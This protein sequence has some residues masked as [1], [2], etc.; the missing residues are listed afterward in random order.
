[1]EWASKNLKIA[2]HLVTGESF[3]KWFQNIQKLHKA[4][5]LTYEYSTASQ[6]VTKYSNEQN[7]FVDTDNKIIVE[8]N[9]MV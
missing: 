3:L 6:T 5:I 7:I 8:K 1:M 9:Q 2:V 4:N